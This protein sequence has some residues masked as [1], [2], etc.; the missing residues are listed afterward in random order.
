MVVKNIQ[1]EEIEGVLS[2]LPGIAQCMVV[3]IPHE[4]YGQRPVAFVQLDAAEVSDD[5]MVEF[6]RG[7]LPGFKVQKSRSFFPMAQ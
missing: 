7:R 4:E 5:E 2:E 3:P 1:P 6:L